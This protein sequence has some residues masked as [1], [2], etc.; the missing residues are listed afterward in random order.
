MD[1]REFLEE[2]KAVVDGEIS[3]VLPRDSPIPGLYD[4][5]LDFIDEGGKRWRPILCLLVHRALGG[6]GETVL[7]YAAAIEL[8]HNFSL[9]HDDIE[10]GDESRRG[11]PTLW[12]LHGVPKSINIGD[13][14]LNK[15]YESVTRL[16]SV[17]VGAEKILWCL[18]MLCSSMV[19]LSEGQALEMDF[20][21]RWDVSEAEYMDMVWRKTGTLVSAA[22]AGGAYLADAP[23]SVVLDMIEYG[24]L[25]GPAFQI[26][27]DV[28]NVSGD[29]EKYLKEIGGDIREGKRTLMVI[30]LLER[31][32]AS[33][34]AKIEEILGQPRGETT[35][36]DCA[37]V[38]RLMDTH[39]SVEHARRVAES[40]IS[41]AKE[42]LLTLPDTE[43]RTL[44]L[45]LTE[46][47]VRRDY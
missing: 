41:G 17:G 2:Q 24:R 38:L 46:F 36:E 11:K 9:I 40:R 3:K 21:G 44:L 7:P 33:E 16:E 28:L 47:L 39:G 23:E 34:R 35:Q 26:I 1:L 37:Y 14:M 8:V 18:R 32:S 6:R 29:Y 31:A 20:L 27:D 22:V 4:V 25:I 12:V 43:E 13:N 30:H 42:K 45:Q 10:D 15:A 19:T 5:Q